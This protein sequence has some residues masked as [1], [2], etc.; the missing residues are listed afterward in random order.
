VYSLYYQV[1]WLYSAYALQP[2]VASAVLCARLYRCE[3]SV[4]FTSLPPVSCLRQAVALYYAIMGADGSMRGFTEYLSGEP[5]HAFYQKL[6][7]TSRQPAWLRPI[8]SALLKVLGQVSFWL[9]GP[10]CQ[11]LL[12]RLLLKCLSN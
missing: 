2:I 7:L 8:V 10:L 12:L 6:H 11:L 3:V 9:T 1:A 4:R 5:L